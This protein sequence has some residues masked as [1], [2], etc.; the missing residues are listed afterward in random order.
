MLGVNFVT[1]NKRNN[2]NAKFK[3]N[4]VQTTKTR[5]GRIRRLI[6]RTSS[7]TTEK[8]GKNVQSTIQIDG[9]VNN[10][11]NSVDLSEEAPRNNS[12]RD[13]SHSAV[14]LIHF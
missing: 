2:C 11:G 14:C 13:R 8:N 7:D 3:M 10:N 5:S 6:D 1:F 4:T 9:R 12:K